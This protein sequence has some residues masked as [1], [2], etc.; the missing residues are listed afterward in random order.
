MSRAII[1]HRASPGVS[2]Q[3]M[4]RPGNLT[5]GLSRGG[6]ADRIALREGAALLGQ[7]AGLAAIEM[8]AAGGI[9]EFTAQTRIALTGA[10]MR[11][12]LEGTRLAWGASHLVPMGAAL[13]IGPAETG[14]YGYLSVG[15]GVDTPEVLGAR[16]THFAAGLGGALMAGDRLPLGEDPG[17]RTNMCLAPE[18][19]FG[20]GT[21][22]FVAS[23]QTAL[24]GAEELA[25]FEATVFHRDIRANRMGSR[26]V[27]DGDG[28]GAAS[29][30]SIVSEVIVPGDIQVTGDGTPFV[31]LAECGTT[32]GYPRIGSV[33]PCDLATVA[34][35]PA[36]ATLRF[37]FVTLDEAMEIET[38]HAR[39]LDARLA[40]PVP[41]VRDPRSMRDLLGYEF[42]SGVTDG[43][44]FPDGG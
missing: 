41:L 21:L 42:I 20:G 25:R 28:F 18:Q 7:D 1:V 14:F 40:A 30:L 10:R 5:F 22:R 38:R 9:F 44:T 31:L 24:F 12:S 35:A 3:D 6:A 26:F 13:T 2:V 37:K 33:L 39:T 15:G 16:G 4:G 32:G 34:Q 27:P 36:G 29:G 19:R 43:R 11:A 8:P 23:A 17:T